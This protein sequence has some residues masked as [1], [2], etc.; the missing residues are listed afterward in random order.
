MF[1]LKIYKLALHGVEVAKLLFD[2]ALKVIANG[3]NVLVFVDDI[4]ILR[5]KLVEELLVAH[6]KYLEA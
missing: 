6:V 5:T 2:F 1:A 3:S 4:L